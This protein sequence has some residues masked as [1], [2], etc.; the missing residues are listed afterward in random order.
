MP[1]LA[2]G[3]ASNEPSPQ[4]VP[5]TNPALATGEY[6]LGLP[7]VATASATDFD[8][9]WSA[10]ERVARMRMFPIDRRDP[11][12]GLLTTEP[13]V[14]SQLFEPWRQDQT[15]GYDTAQSSLTTRRRTVRFEISRTESGE[16]RLTPKV[17]VEQYAQAENRVTN[18][19][20]YRGAF[21]ATRQTDM[22]PYG[23]RESDRGIFLENRYWYAIGRD[24]KLEAALAADIQ[25]AVDQTAAR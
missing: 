15:D 20:L 13:V 10:A 1:F 9:L 2:I 4:P 25:R 22:T 11:R 16:F 19:V 12:N 21:R 6:W 18:V 5:T 17:L 7:G 24:E 23:T 8:S 3:C 14:S